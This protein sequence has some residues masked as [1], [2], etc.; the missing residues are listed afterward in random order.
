MGESATERL[1]VEGLALEPDPACQRLLSWDLRL[2]DEPALEVVR[3]RL[4]TRGWNDESTMAFL[5]VL[6]SPALHRVLLV[7]S[8]GRIQL[9]LHYSTAATDRPR[10][11]LEVARAL[12]P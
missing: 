5:W 7:P 9:R 2:S 1:E 11:A 3:S 4:V 6:S 12:L 10:V 8:T